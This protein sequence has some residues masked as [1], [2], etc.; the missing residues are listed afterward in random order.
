M[1]TDDDFV[2]GLVQIILPAGPDSPTLN[3]PNHPKETNTMTTA[4]GPQLE[5]RQAS[6]PRGDRGR[7]RTAATDL[8]RRTRT[9]LRSRRRDRYRLAAVH[10][11]RTYRSSI[12]H[13]GH[14][15]LGSFLSAFRRAR[16]PV[17][18]YTPSEAIV[19][20]GPCRLTRNPAY[21]GMA[22]TY[23]GTAGR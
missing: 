14:G 11:R 17:D 2:T 19:T 21:L 1:R 18:P 7:D 23:A 4:V 8:P 12:D 3:T 5:A 6:K 20:D 13:R 9:R 15:L 16:T 22:L 10:G